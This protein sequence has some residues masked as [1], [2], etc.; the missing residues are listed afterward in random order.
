MS[1]NSFNRRKFLQATALGGVGIAIGST[2][3]CSVPAKSE[4][5]SKFPPLKLGLMTYNLAKNWDIETIIKN[6]T[7]TGY[8]HVELRTTHKHGVEVS[9]SKKERAE[10]KKRF[11]D[12]SFEAI[13]LASAFRYHS[14]DPVELKENIEG[15]KEYL[16]LAADVGAI[17]IRVFPNEFPKSVSRKK[18]IAQ[19]G[20][21][22][23]EVGEFGHN[24]GVD[25]RVCAH[26]KGTAEIPV[27]KSIFDASGSNHVYMNWN[28]NPTDD[29]GAGLEKNFN[30]I[31]DRIRG[32]HLHEM[33]DEYPYRQF[34][35]LLR[36]S[37]YNGYCNAEISGSSDPIRVM[38]YYRALFL[39]LQNEI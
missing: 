17:G 7:E 9:L 18:T 19:I 8:V 3:Q 30:M 28:C 25:V 5:K 21:A 34:F 39:A 1:T 36:E 15:T 38:K 29:D 32:V 22:L 35:S 16:Q 11:E 33:Y 2:A 24:L 20:K 37:G 14:T 6:C 31:K 26:G 13:S 10:V 23:A 4:T 27:V 12:S